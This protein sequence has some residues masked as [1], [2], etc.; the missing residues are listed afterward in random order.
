ML[1]YVTKMEFKSV[2]FYFLRNGC[3]VFL[4]VYQH[5]N[6]NGNI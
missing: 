2:V 3:S 6:R 4:I 1:V 5:G